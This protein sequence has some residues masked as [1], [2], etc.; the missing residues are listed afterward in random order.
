VRRPSI[1]VVGHDS[2]PTAFI[3]IHD[4]QWIDTIA[5][6]YPVVGDIDILC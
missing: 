6:I 1:P 5:G 3:L 2:L 4:I